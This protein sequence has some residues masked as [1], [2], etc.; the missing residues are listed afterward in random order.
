MGQSF[1]AAC[2][3][4]QL[5]KQEWHN[6]ILQSCSLNAVKGRS[7]HSTYLSALTF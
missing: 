3:P 7:G 4:D 2:L 5:Q 1:S 6:G